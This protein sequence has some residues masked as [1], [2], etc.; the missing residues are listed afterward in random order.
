MATQWSEGILLAELGDEPE[1]SEELSAL[2]ERIKA[3]AGGG[4]GGAGGRA[5]H[6]VLNFTAVSYLNSSH[7]AALLRLRK[8]LIEQRRQLVLCALN[9]EVLSVFLLTGLDKVFQFEQN[10]MTA[11][12]RVQLQEGDGRTG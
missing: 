8:R 12:A 11:L 3:G 1:L 5:S 10:T 6:L 2:F 4:G 9:E 7:I